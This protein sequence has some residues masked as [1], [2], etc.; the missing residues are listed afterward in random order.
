MRSNKLFYRVLRLFAVVLLLSRAG[1]WVKV[2][3]SRR[4]LA[5]SRRPNRGYAPG[6]NKG[7]SGGGLGENWKRVRKGSGYAA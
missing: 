6:K 2:A 3:R 4:R 7:K 5:A 1:V